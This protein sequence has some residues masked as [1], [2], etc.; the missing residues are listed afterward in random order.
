MT[1]PI[2]ILVPII[3]NAELRKALL[4]YAIGVAGLTAGVELGATTTPSAS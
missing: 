3:D 1:G 4:W 2:L